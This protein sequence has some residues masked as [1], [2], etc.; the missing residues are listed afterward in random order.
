MILAFH[1]LI[2]S[3]QNRK[4]M[5]KFVVKEMESLYLEEL[6]TS[7]NL[8]M[9]N[10]ESQPVSKASQEGKYGLKNLRKYNNR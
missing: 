1:S 8:L 5:P 10:L 2:F 9:A 6:K 4:L 7:I 3:Y